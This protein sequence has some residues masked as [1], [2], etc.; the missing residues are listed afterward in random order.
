MEFLQKIAVR[1]YHPDNTIPHARNAYHWVFGSNEAGR[2]GAGAAKVAKINFGAEYGV[3][4][5]PTGKAYAIP[6]K[7][8]NLGILP[9]DVVKENV[10]EFLAYARANPNTQFFVT[11]IGCGLAKNGDEEIGPLFADAPPNCILP[12]DWKGYVSQL[13]IAPQAAL[14]EEADCAR[15]RMSGV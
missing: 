5:G 7:D 10:V 15:E 4:R 14:H 11:R 8:R 1:R 6:T 2:H 3:G 13:G 9:L 12:V